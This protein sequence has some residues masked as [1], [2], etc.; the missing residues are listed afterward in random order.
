VTASASTVQNGAKSS[1]K[2]FTMG[3]EAAENNGHVVTGT[4]LVNSTPSFVLFDSGATN[5]FVSCDHIK[6]LGL[7]QFSIISD[8]VDIP[9]GETVL[10]KRLYR[11]VPIR[12]GEVDFSADLMEFPLGGFE[13]ILG[14]DWLGKYRAFIDCYQKKVTLRG[15]KGK[16][17]SY[18]AFVV[19]PKVKL[20]STITLKAC[21]R[22]GGQ[23]VYVPCERH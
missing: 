2:L 20:I 17:V 18:R 12:I 4:F 3:K 6:T 15:P 8:V 14:M 7:T 23:F 10:C 1:G 11:N 16:R 19:K 21:L 5:S 9:S 22:K 13:I